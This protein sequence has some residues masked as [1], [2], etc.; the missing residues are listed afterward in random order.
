MTSGDVYEIGDYTMGDTGKDDGLF[1]QV[2]NKAA[3]GFDVG[4]VTALPGIDIAA[5]LAA[6][7]TSGA[8]VA[9]LESL[10]AAEAG[11]I[12]LDNVL[13]TAAAVGIDWD[14]FIDMLPESMRDGSMFPQWAQDAYGEGKELYEAVADSDI[15]QG[16]QDIYGEIRD[17]TDPIEDIFGGIGDIFGEFDLGPLDSFLPQAPGMGPGWCWRPT[18]PRAVSP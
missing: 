2:L 1:Q 16:A 7:Y 6:P 10:K 15:V 8:S 13:R 17:F 3:P 11:D 18:W 12:D 5:A 9:V 14:G 4:D